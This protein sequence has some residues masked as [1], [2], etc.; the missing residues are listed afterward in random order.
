MEQKIDTPQKF[1]ERKNYI[2]VRINE[3]FDFI[4]S[5]NTKFSYTKIIQIAYKVTSN[6]EVKP[7][8]CPVSKLHLFK[9]VEIKFTSQH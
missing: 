6:A 3:L 2:N 8:K 1:I 7:K 4:K 5:K 9:S